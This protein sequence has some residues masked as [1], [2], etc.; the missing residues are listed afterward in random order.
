MTF[1]LIVYSLCI[2]LIAFFLLYVLKLFVFQT[3]SSCFITLLMR[4][5][6][7]LLLKLLFLITGG[8]FENFIYNSNHFLWKIFKDISQ[9]FSQN[10]KEQRSENLYLTVKIK[11]D[12]E[13]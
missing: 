8:T 5:T 4:L 7:I 12:Y 2:P 13:K 10:D 3:E 6:N 11:M 9:L 1:K